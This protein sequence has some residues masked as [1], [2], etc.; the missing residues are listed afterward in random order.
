MHDFTALIHH[1]V[2]NYEHN[3]EKNRKGAFLFI[4]LIK[5]HKSIIL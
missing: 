1:I 4:N 3:W 2:N 5:Y